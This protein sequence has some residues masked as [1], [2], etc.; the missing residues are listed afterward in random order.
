MNFIVPSHP[1]NI[2]SYSDPSTTRQVAPVTSSS[3][4]FA[5]NRDQQQAPTYV[6]RG[7]VLEAVASERRYRPRINL[8]QNILQQRAIL[9][10]QAN[11]R[12]QE[13]ASGKILDG[14]I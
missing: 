10:Y 4:E 14:F 5:S 2:P 7:E 3:A 12:E 8:P 1:L 11:T 9:A 6:Y 13:S